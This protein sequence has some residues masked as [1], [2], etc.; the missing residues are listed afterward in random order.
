MSNR[1]VYDEYFEH[2]PDG[3]DGDVDNALE[4]GSTH[5]RY[6]ATRSI[7]SEQNPPAPDYSAN[8][9]RSYRGLQTYNHHSEPRSLP[10]VPEYSTN[11]SSRAQTHNPSQVLPR[12]PSTSTFVRRASEQTGT[13]PSAH[14][15]GQ[16]QYA[17]A[18]DRPSEG[19]LAQSARRRPVSATSHYLTRH[20]L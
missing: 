3:N 1:T 2:A 19:A 10:T 7:D 18:I 5:P 9:L 8:V 4:A 12:S 20:L 6:Y 11:A 17:D 16:S 15:H 14:D 13:Y